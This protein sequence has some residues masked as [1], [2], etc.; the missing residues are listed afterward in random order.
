MGHYSYLNF[1]HFKISSF[2]FLCFTMFSFYLGFHKSLKIEF[3][4]KTKNKAQGV[5]SG[6]VVKVTFICMLKFLP[7]PKEHQTLE[8]SL[9]V[10]DCMQIHQ[11]FIFSKVT[12]LLQLYYIKLGD[13]QMKTIQ[14]MSQVLHKL[15]SGT[16]MVKSTDVLGF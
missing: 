13:T 15:R 14:K 6:E 3:F 11:M 8:D 10:K 16:T 4:L 7:A 12:K 2:L 9:W 1:R 5:I